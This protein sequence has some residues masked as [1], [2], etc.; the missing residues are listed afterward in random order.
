[1]RPRLTKIGLTETGLTANG[2][3]NMTIA[4]ID[5]YMKETIMAKTDRLKQFAKHAEGSGTIG[6]MSRYDM[7]EFAKAL[8]EALGPDDGPTLESQPIDTAP[9]DGTFILVY[10]DAKEG[11]PPFL[12]IVNYHPDAGWCCDEVRDATRW[13]PQATPAIAALF[14]LIGQSQQ[15]E[16]PSLIG[17]TILDRQG[18]APRFVLLEPGSFAVVKD[19]NSGRYVT[20]RMAK[21]TQ[22]EA[23]AGLEELCQLVGVKFSSLDIVEEERV[24]T[25]RYVHNNESSEVLGRPLS[26]GPQFKLVSK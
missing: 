9:K 4:T 15:S 11:L 16:P 18:W 3:E 6:T 7:S 14:R 23:E 22:K 2:V 19:Q 5:R 13:Y 25:M 24:Y 17:G 21:P 12:A 10:V 1:M 8:A 20:L 26:Y